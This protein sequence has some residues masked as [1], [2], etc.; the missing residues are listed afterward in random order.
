M[1][2]I[3]T[4]MTKHLETFPER[5]RELLEFQKKTM[6]EFGEIKKQIKDG[7][8]HPEPAARTIAMIGEV[9]DMVLEHNKKSLDLMK[10]YTDWRD[11]TSKALEQ[12]TE[13]LPI[14]KEKLLPAYDREVQG[15]MAV[16][17]LKERLSSLSFWIKGVMPFFAFIY[18]V[19]YLI[20]KFP[21]DH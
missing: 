16:K 5:R 2:Q 21:L 8:R 9:K 20:R 11:S 12:L 4:E 15:E 3:E 17:W 13:L 10:E 1:N 7:L 14:V 19:I 18:G 6:E